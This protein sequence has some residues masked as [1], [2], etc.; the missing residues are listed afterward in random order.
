MM[1][2][3]V[4]KTERKKPKVRSVVVLDEDDGEANNWQDKSPDKFPEQF[5]SYLKRID[6]NVSV[7]HEVKV[8]IEKEVKDEK[9]I[10]LHKVVPVAGAK[11]QQPEPLDALTH[12]FDD[13]C[14]SDDVYASLPY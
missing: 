10:Q 3:F 5:A 12:N 14:L 11:R 13:D 7:E 8:K 6:G 1:N 2:S 4:V 9:K